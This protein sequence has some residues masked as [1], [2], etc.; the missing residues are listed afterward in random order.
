MMLKG[1]KMEKCLNCELTLTLNRHGKETDPKF[2]INCGKYIIKDGFATELDLEAEHYG[3]NHDNLDNEIKRLSEY[4]ML[5]IRIPES[6]E[7]RGRAYKMKGQY[8]E[9]IAD[10]TKLIGLEP[11]RYENYGERA[12]VYR[13]NGQ[14]DEAISDF[15][16]AIEGAED[17]IK[18]TEAE[19]VES[20]TGFEFEVDEDRD[21][22]LAKILSFFEYGRLSPAFYLNERAYAYMYKGEFDKA[23]ADINKALEMR[24]NSG[25][26]WDTR[27]EIYEA[28][29]EYQ[30]AIDDC[31]KALEL[32]PGLAST[33]EILKRCEG[34]LRFIRA[35]N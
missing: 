17:H 35:Y 1:E 2:C 32:E 19:G 20:K 3:F 28:A 22:D 21:D 25:G 13:K 16:R 14:Y 33:M 23:I 31:N 27:A 10:Y 18:K 5:D 30:K 15:T 4:I 6:Y 8:A 26:Y 34:R 11:E 9:A 7:N 29:G 24:P 12:S